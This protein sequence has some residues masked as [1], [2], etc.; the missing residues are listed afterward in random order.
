MSALGE[1]IHLYYSHYRDYGVARINESPKIANYSLNV[2]NRRINNEVP[3]IKKETITELQRRLKLN[4]QSNLEKGKSEQAKMQQKLLDQVYILLYE[5]LQKIQD[6]ERLR[7]KAGGNFWS[8]D[9]EGSKFH[10]LRESHWASSLSTDELKKRRDQAKNLYQKI[11]KLII[12]INGQTAQ[13]SLNKLF[14]LEKLYEQYTHLSYDSDD[15][16]LVAIQKA[17][18]QH[19]YNNTKQQISGDFGEM[20]LATLGDKIFKQANQTV[21]QAIEESVK[22]QQRTE[23]L[24]DKSLISDNRGD[25]I[26]KQ[27]SKD[28]TYY[29][30]KPTQNK[31]DV[32]IQIADDNILASMKTYSGTGS[33]SFRPDLQEVNLFYSIL[34]LNSYN[35]LKDIGNHWLNLHATHPGK[36]FDTVNSNQIDDIIKREVAFEALSSGNPFKQGINN[37]N[38][39]VYI[40][41]D[42]GQIYIKSIKDIL[43]NDFSKIGGLD[44]IS[45]IRLQNRRTDKIEDRIT[46]VL[47]QLHQQKISVALNIKFD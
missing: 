8:V 4:S 32:Q 45:K 44:R 25:Q 31:V 21:A 15:H 41:R 18:T 11:Q 12:E 24:I 34:F 47:N 7:E 30:M 2:I 23:I 3:D 28:G 5:R 1:Y 14:E 17:I 46:N 42:T 9:K 19:R 13:Q 22:G 36:A 33:H 20:L 38:V 10:T 43:F 26:F 16:S 39:F 37:A 29:Y 6:M 27:T 40:N 35:E